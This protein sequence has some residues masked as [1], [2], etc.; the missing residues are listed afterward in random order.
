M[1]SVLKIN[2]TSCLVTGGQTGLGAALVTELLERGAAKV[3]AASRHP[4]PTNDPRIVAVRLDVTDPTQVTALAELVND[5]S[6]V[7]NNAGSYAAADLLTGSA[8]NLRL[9]YE[10]NALGPLWVARAFAPVLAAHGGGAL[11]NVHS[12]LSWISGRDGYSASK[13]AAWSI[14]NGLRAALAPAGTLVVGLHVGYMDTALTAH[15]TDVEKMD[16]R[17]VARA[18]AQGLIDNASEVLADEFSR[19]VKSTLSGDP[20]HLAIPA[21]NA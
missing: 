12:V 6:I 4:A 20:R 1:R 9:D 8:A 18:A 7:V 3:Y 21:G 5:V 15:V 16:P 13:A 14:T 10:T 2:G 17:D 11:L 19:G